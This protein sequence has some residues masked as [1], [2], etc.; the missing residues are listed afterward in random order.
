MRE[1]R[2]VVTV[3][4]TVFLAERLVYE[5]VARAYQLRSPI[6]RGAA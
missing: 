3:S 1:R 2:P 6:S 4:D 5:S